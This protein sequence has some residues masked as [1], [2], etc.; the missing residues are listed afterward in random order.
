MSGAGVLINNRD[1]FGKLSN[2]ETAILAEMLDEFAPH[3][4]PNEGESNYFTMAKY[5]KMART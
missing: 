3:E 1:D 4:N 5:Q 2:L